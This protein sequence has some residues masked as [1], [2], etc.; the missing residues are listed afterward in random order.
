MLLYQWNRGV[1]KIELHHIG[2]V[3][4]SKLS[5]CLKSV[6]TIREVRASSQVDKHV[7]RM[8]YW[9]HFLHLPFVSYS[10]LTHYHFLPVNFHI[11]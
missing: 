11:A 6:M 4:Y 3:K 5:N 8:T 10:L 7:L 1:Y 9:M 2:G